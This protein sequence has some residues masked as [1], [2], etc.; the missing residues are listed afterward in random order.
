MAI[1]EAKKEKRQRLCKSGFCDRKCPTTNPVLATPNQA[2]DTAVYLFTSGTTGL[3][4]A[5]PSSHRK[6]FKA[7]GGFGH[8]CLS[9]TSDDVIYVTLPFYHGTA[10]LVCWG[11]RWQEGQ[12]SRYVANLAPLNSGMMC[13]A[14]MPPALVMSANFAVTC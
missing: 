13:V 2:G 6:W 12:P 11:L 10:L 7:Y 1:P 4:K 3:P 8:M 9:L 14:T 5:A